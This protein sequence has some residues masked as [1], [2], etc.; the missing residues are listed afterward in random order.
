M[1]RRGTL[2]GG[3]VERDAAWCC[4][5]RSFELSEVPAQALARVTADSR[6]VLFLNGREVS[7]GPVRSNPRRL[8]YD[9]L[10]LAPRLRRGRN[11]LAALVR[12]FGAANPV[13]M[14][15]PAAFQLGAGAFL[16]E[17]ELGGGERLASDARW[18]AL[19]GAGWRELLGRGV[20][21]QPIEI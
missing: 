4:L 13:W 9:A 20:A 15:V 16:F 19:A 17:A 2:L 11:Q 5:R 12:Y 14:P 7:R 3:H 18:K 1:R 8:R 21:A 10:D 6:Y